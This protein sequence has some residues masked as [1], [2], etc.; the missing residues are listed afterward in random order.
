M[1]FNIQSIVYQLESVGFFYL[2]LPFLLVFAVVFGIL[3][4]TRIFGKNKG[5]HVLIAFVIAAMALRWNFFLSDFFTQ[6]FSRLGIGIAILLTVCILIGLWIPD[7]NQRW[8]AYGLAG[9][10]F[11]IAVVI[12]VQSFERFGWTGYGFLATNAGFIIGAILIVGLIVIVV[13][14]S[15]KENGSATPRTTVNGSAAVTGFPR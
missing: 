7:D 8:F 11:I 13:V 4:T 10:G 14:T 1:V 9:I 12:V 15:G 6:I 2:L 3:Q 5:I